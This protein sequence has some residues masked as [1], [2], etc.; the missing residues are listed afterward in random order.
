MDSLVPGSLVACA[1]HVLTLVHVKE[2]SPLETSNLGQSCR[3]RDQS[4]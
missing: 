3:L 1:T 4:Q 2:C